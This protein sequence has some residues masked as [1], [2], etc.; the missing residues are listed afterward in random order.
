M[1][2]MCWCRKGPRQNCQ[3]KETLHINSLNI[4]ILKLYM[5]MFLIK[6]L[7]AVSQAL[8]CFTLIS[9]FYKSDDYLN[10]LKEILYAK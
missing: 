10:E 2:A 6:M 4:L 8:P 5:G 9:V 1:V 3:L 7:I